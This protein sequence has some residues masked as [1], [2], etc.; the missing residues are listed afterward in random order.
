MLAVLGRAGPD[1]PRRRRL[2]HPGE[3]RIVL[4]AQSVLKQGGSIGLGLPGGAGLLHGADVAAVMA[5]S[6]SAVL[7]GLGTATVTPR[8]SNTPK[9]RA[10]CMVSSTRTGAIGCPGPKS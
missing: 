8:A 1:R 4:G 2:V 5:R 6:S 7:A 3:Y 9:V 10:S